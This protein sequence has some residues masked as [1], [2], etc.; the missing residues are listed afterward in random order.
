MIRS[1]ERDRD[2]HARR[3]QPEP[4]VGVVGEDGIK[5]LSRE[6]IR[7]ARMSE[8][9]VAAVQEREQAS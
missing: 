4:G 8:D 1:L 9:E 2:P 6:I 7:L 3:A 5:V